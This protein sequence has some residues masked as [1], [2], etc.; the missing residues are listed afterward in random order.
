MSDAMVVSTRP[1]VGDE[2]KCYLLNGN[3][4][5]ADVEI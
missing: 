1:Q 4:A 5:S 3:L 2:A